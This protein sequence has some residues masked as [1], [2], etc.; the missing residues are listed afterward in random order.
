MV[1]PEWITKLKEDLF[2][3]PFFVG[4]IV[5]HPSGRKVKITSGAFWVSGRLS[6]FWNWREVREDGTLSEVEEHGYGW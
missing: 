3:Q 2:Q 1:E 4:D 5:S 6:N